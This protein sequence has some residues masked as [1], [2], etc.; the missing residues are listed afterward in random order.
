MVI[1]GEH[2]LSRRC[3][4]LWADAEDVGR[5]G[6][7]ELERVLGAT[8]SAPGEMDSPGAD[9]LANASPPRARRTSRRE[10]AIP[11]LFRSRKRF[12]GLARNVTTMAVADSA[13][14]PTPHAL[15]RIFVLGFEMIVDSLEE[16]TERL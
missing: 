9:S 12:L 5:V 10:T 2:G 3:C 14:Q 7:S 16:V 11:A 8:R 6:W 13:T 15:P 4:A 1:G